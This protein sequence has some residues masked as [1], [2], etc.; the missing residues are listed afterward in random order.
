MSL[1]VK[2]GNLPPHH[3]LVQQPGTSSPT[4]QVEALFCF[5][6]QV[7]NREP[8]FHSDRSCDIFSHVLYHIFF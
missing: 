4:S 7:D 6:S 1:K 2:V 3:V 5:R 8:I